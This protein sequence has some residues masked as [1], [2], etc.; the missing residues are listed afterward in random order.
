MTVRSLLFAAG[1]GERLRPLS[2]RVPKPALP[3]L[4]V[5]LGA[6]GL[7]ALLDAAPPALVNVS[8]MADG[9]IGAL[10]RVSD[11]GWEVLR[12]EPA[13]YG[14]A[15]TLRALVDR[16]EDR[17]VTHNSDVIATIEVE[18]VVVTHDDLGTPVTICGGPVPEGADFAVEDDRATGFYDR[19]RGES[20]PGVVF[21][22]VAVFE[23]RA[24]ERIPKR[25]PL[26]LGETLLRDLATEGELGVHLHTGYSRDVG[27][28]GAYAR[29]TLD[30]LA[31]VAPKPPVAPPGDTAETDGGRAYVGP[32]ASVDPSSLG[33]EAVVLAGAVVESGAYVERSVVCPGERVPAG[34]S[35]RNA[36]WAFGREIALSG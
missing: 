29:V 9:V 15:G 36:V 4:D 2:D 16:I 13:A 10:R 25:V 33:D 22:G 3:I 26:G 6:W 32:G 21:T 28:F 12:E 27:T 30:V 31:G 19:R 17:I 8:Y 1:R 7:A 34:T 5:P 14:T 23:R 11:S 20:G 35:V 24:V 18:D